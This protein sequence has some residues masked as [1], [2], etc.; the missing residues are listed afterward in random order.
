[1]NLEQQNLGILG[2]FVLTMAG[3]FRFG[4]IQHRRLTDQFVHFLEST[5]DR[6]LQSLD[7]LSKVIQ[8]NTLT[9][10]RWSDRMDLIIGRGEHAI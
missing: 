7:Q 1:M 5:T 10:H 6:W 9:V 3:L 2:T 4:M 8:E